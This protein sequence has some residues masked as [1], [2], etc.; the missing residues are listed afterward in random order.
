MSCAARW[1]GP[2][3]VPPGPPSAG[4]FGVLARPLGGCRAHAPPRDDR[5]CMTDPDRHPLR[6]TTPGGLDIAPPKPFVDRRRRTRRAA[7][8]LADEETRLLAMALDALAADRPAEARLADL[9]DLLADTV[10]ATR[11]A[12]IADGEARRIAVAASGP[13]DL[14]AATELAT[15]LDA[16]APR[17]RAQRAATGPAEVVIANRVDATPLRRRGAK[18]NDPHYAWL[19]IPAASNVTLG[20]AFAR[21]ADAAGLPERMPPALARHAAVALALVTESM[22]TERELTELRAR[23]VLVEA[24][25]M[26]APPVVTFGRSHKAK[27]AAIR[28]PRAIRRSPAKAAAA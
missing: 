2:S 9:L 8:R 5:R 24:S 11:T 4:T 12:V 16:T 3:G 22:T 7:D 20:F 10:G 28:T 19:P 17:S 18:V 1:G 27:I 23:E 15:W 14:S 6:P 25:L 26:N 21:K 13:D